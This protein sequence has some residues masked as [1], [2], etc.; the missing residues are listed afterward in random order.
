[1]ATLNTPRPGAIPAALGLL[2]TW[3][4][5]QSCQL[6]GGYQSF[7]GHPCNVLPA[8]KLDARGMATL[9]LSKQPDGTCYWIDKTEVTVQQYTTFLAAVL[10]D[11]QAI[12][13]SQVGALEQRTQ[14]CSW[15]T[16]PS[17]PVDD[18]TDTCTQTTT[19]EAD[20]FAASKPIRCID[21]CDAEAFCNW[22]GKDLCGGLIN[23]SFVG[24]ADV[25]D[26]WGLACSAGA[27]SYITGSMAVN[28]ACNVGLT[29]AQCYSELHE[30]QCGPTAVGSFAE[31][32]SPGGVVDMIGNVAEWVLSCASS[33]GGPNTLCQVRGGSFND[34]LVKTTCFSVAPNARGTRDRGI[35]I[36]CCE[37]L[38]IAEQNLTK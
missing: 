36:R 13:W 17:D 15:K 4:A 6:V 16:A 18:T 28:G 10:P 9:V 31:C 26:Q 38:S 20:A 7:Q 30:P 33:D 19:V 11:A 37:R 1:M 21:W 23:G 25:A 29:E 3:V 5:A 32:T 2:A 27:Q 24:P 22:A 8:S 34:D 14:V 35:G 12:D